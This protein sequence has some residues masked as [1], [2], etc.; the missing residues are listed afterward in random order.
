MNGQE[1]ATSAHDQRLLQAARGGDREALAT[2]LEKHQQRVFGFGMKMCGDPE[3]AKDVAQDTL[4]A[5]V[6]SLRDFRGD[7]SISTWLYTVARSFCIKKRRRT[8]GAPARHDPLDR[9]VAEKAFE[10]ELGPEQLLLGREAREIVAA[11]LDEMEPEAR[12]IVLLRDIEGLSAPEVAKVT[13][14]SVS[15]V[16]SRLHRARLSLRERLRPVVGEPSEPATPTC[17]D[18]LTLLSKKLEAEV[19]PEL[20]AEMERHVDGCPHCKGLCDS[21]KRTLA[22]CSSL[23]T[24]SVPPHVQESLRLAVR[25]ALKEGPTV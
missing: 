25:E 10:P 22:V 12:E 6:R 18:V 5:A 23:P 17:P 4:L 7:A 3:D 16:K 9:A 11:A 14:L 2:L 19:S 21:L 24:P 13:G 15:A 20:C 1:A 8:K